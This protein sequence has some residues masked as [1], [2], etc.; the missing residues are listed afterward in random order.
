M[1]SQMSGVH[2][3]MSA[4]PPSILLVDDDEDFARELLTRLV[5]NHM[6]GEYAL[7]ASAARG[8]IERGLP[9][10]IVVDK[11][12]PDEDGFRL[13]EAIKADPRTSLV[14]IIG[15]SGDSAEAVRLE[16]LRAGF[17]HW[18]PKPIDVAELVVRINVL[19]RT[20]SVTRATAAKTEGLLLWRDWVRFLVHDLRN[21]VAVAVNNLGLA[22]ENPSPDLDSDV[23]QALAEAQGELQRVAAML[24]DLLDTERLQRGL[25]V[26]K[27]QRCSL[28]TV[29]RE[30]ARSMRVLADARR[31]AILVEGMGDTTVEADPGLLERVCANL[32]GNAIRYARRRPIQ[33]QVDGEGAE[34]TIRVQNDG[35]AVLPEVRARLFEPWALVSGSVGGGTQGTGL[36]LA[37]C[38]LAV[39]AH[40]GRIWLEN[41]ADGQVVFAVRLPRRWVRAHS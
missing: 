40:G 21:P 35:P 32:V 19:V 16:A 34:V 31:T 17:D 7:D 1:S 24:Q 29:V 23:Q 41:A 2:A 4:E 14:P 28:L 38:R 12:L 33:V 37:F 26:P 15:V 30:V 22:L 13:C 39:E 36:G 11:Y 18:L 9:D 8:S 6:K 5:A 27:H 3:A 25:L 20:S 10:L